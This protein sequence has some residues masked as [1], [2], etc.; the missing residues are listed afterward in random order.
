MNREI[1][2]FSV[3]DAAYFKYMQGLVKS[4][5]INFPEAR[6]FVELVN[7]DKESALLLESQHPKIQVRVINKIFDCE[8]SKKCFCASRRASLFVE[9]FDSTPTP[10][11]WLDA[12]SLVRRPCKGL[13]DLMFSCDLSMRQKRKGHFASG[14]ICLGTS[15]ICKQFAIRYEECVNAD[16]S[17]MSDQNNLNKVHR[18]FRKRINFVPLP[19][20]YCDVWFSEEGAIWAAKARKKTSKK[21][22]HELNRFLSM[23]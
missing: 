19:H 17:W 5:A 18:I 4:A 21:Y 10:M 3:A 6:M 13:V 2:L 15:D 22:I 16:H 1:L 14:T 23:E 20:T 12:D 9:L 8:H 7:M 11:M